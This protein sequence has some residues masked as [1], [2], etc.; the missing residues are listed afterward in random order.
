M[1]PLFGCAIW[2]NC[3]NSPIARDTCH[4]TLDT[5]NRAPITIA[6]LVS[7]AR[8]E[9]QQHSRASVLSRNRPAT[10]AHSPL[11]RVGNEP[12]GGY[13]TGHNNYRGGN[14]QRNVPFLKKKQK[15]NVILDDGNEEIPFSAAKDLYK[16]EAFVANID[17]RTNLTAIKNH[18]ARKLQTS[19]IFLKPMS[20]P[21]ASYISF[22]FFCKSERDDLD[23]KMRGLWPKGTRIYKWN[24]KARDTGASSR[25]T[26]PNIRGSAGGNHGSRFSN[27]QYNS[28][29]GYRLPSAE[30][31]RLHNQHV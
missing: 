1:D 26:G 30:Q 4:E 11:P 20:K 6:E 31:R 21:D 12:S 25:V 10:R 16:Y 27:A 7:S 24:S 15:R 19:E 5:G 17:K 23:L 13:Q 22:G 28:P 9:Q 2:S 8:Q 18:A 3:A 14:V 29:E